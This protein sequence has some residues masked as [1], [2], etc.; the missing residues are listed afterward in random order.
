MEKTPCPV[1]ILDKEV[2]SWS[3]RS[4]ATSTKTCYITHERMYLTFCRDISCT[5]VPIST[6]NLCRYAAYLG[7]TYCYST[8]QQY[9]NVVR[10]LHLE[11]GYQNPMT[12]NF[13][14]HT[15]LLGMKRVKGNY[16]HF[17][18]PISPRELMQFHKKMDLANM[19]DLQVWCATLI[20]FFGVLRI[21]SVCTRTKTYIIQRSVV[22]RN[23]LTVTRNGCTLNIS[24]LKSNQFGERKQTVV[25][26]RIKGHSLCPTASLTRFLASG[27]PLGRPLHTQICTHIPLHRF[28]STPCTLHMNSIFDRQYTKPMPKFSDELCQ[29]C[30]GQFEKIIYLGLQSI[31]LQR[32]ISQ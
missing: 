17:K 28:F 11:N 22:C 19:S 18:Q 13:Q 6:A 4:L 26:Q 7:R 10:I 23:D 21:S 5:A 31:T 1:Q 8:V 2:A 3:S 20:C 32:S 24:H 30:Q 15:V 9:L 14:L 16:S 27:I 29:G 25:L 12:N